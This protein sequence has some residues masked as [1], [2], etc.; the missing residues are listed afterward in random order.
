MIRLLRRLIAK[1][2]HRK[3]DPGSLAHEKWETS[4]PAG[5]NKRLEEAE[6]ERFF[7]GVE[8]GAFQLELRRSHLFAWALNSL[9]RYRNF[10]VDLE[11]ELAEENGHSA[12]GAVFRYANGENYYYALVS[13]DGRFRLDVVFNGNPMTLIPWLEIPL[14]ES[15]FT[16][17]IIAHNDNLSFYIDREWIAEIDDETVASGYLGFA[18]QNYGEGER[19]RFLLHRLALES[20]PMEVEVLYYRW[21]RFMRPDPERR[22][23][24]ARRLFGFE[25]Y[26]VALIQLRRAFADK[27]ASAADRFFAAE[28][29]INLGMYGAA[30]EDVEQVL[31]LDPDHREAR[32]EKANLLYL[33]NRFLDAKEY[34]AQIIH[35][36]PEHAV[37]H[38][39]YGNVEF[40]LGNWEDSAQLYLRAC[41]LE[42]EMPIFLLNAARGLEN[43]GRRHEAV[44]YYL[45]AARL[46]FRQ[47]GLEDLPFIFARLEELAPEEPELRALKGKSAF[48]NGDLL[49]ARR[50]FDELIERG[51]AESD[52]FFLRGIL[53]A[54]EGDWERAVLSLRRAVELEP[55]EGLYWMKLAE[56]LHHAGEDPRDALAKARELDPENGWVHHLH[57]LIALEEGEVDTAEELLYSAWCRLPEEEEVLLNY[58]QALY[59]NRGI[60]AALRIFP[61]KEE[62]SARL[63]NQKGNLYAAERR[64]EEALRWYRQAVEEVPEDPVYLENIAALLFEMEQINEAEDYLRKQLELSPTARGYALMGRIASEKGEL[65]RAEEAFREAI[66]SDAELGWVRLELAE[67]LNRFGRWR[68]AVEQAEAAYGGDAEFKAR[69]FVARIKEEH[70]LRYECAACGREWWVP[71]DIPEQSR[72]R[73]RGEPSGESPAGRCPSCGKVYCIACALEHM[74]E[75]RF[76]CAECGERL[77]LNDDGLKYL[78]VRYAEENA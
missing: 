44:S 35:D 51:E 38:N 48:Q 14:Q 8:Q 25:Q 4:F 62:I 40:A 45:S 57:G 42:P 74:Q 72:V 75:N 36:F 24:L 66:R 18:G 64:Y 77:K 56:A 29:R 59:R 13:S 17:R 10:A 12:A 50:Y 6:N 31:R 23:A 5:R 21:T 52:V 61:A 43:A 22:I 71:R 65:R 37:L 68:E 28:C 33:E 16:L 78:A 41:E 34:L 49:M 7:A 70:E 54:G 46:F 39:L 1:L 47:E 63:A 55:E 67:L 2:L 11:I 69:D 30:L 73:L 53:Q 3:P 76:V 58:S 9:Y 26:T 19:A 15:R 60:D 32:L 20:R 27:E